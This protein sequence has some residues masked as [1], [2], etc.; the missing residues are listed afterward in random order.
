MRQTP[1]LRYTARA[2][3][4]RR[5]R[6]YARGLSL[7]VRRWRTRCEVFA[8]K[9]LILACLGLLWGGLALAGRLGPLALLALL[10]RAL[11]PGVG[12]GVLLLELLER[13]LLG[14][15]P[16]TG[17]VTAPLLLGLRLGVRVGTAG[18]ALPG[19]R[20]AERGEQG[21]RLLVRGGR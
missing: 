8:M 20:H 17:L 12:L 15:G 7:G 6:V 4:Q 2:R 3:P 18:P 5:Q 9:L 10:G 1:N 19:E 11:A 14:L 16:G 13:R 21:D